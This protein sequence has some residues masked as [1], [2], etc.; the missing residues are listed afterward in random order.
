MSSRPRADQY[1]GL[2]RLTE[3]KEN[4]FLREA[5]MHP[6][7]LNRVQG[8]DRAFQFAFEGAAVVHMVSEIGNSEIV[9]V[10]EFKPDTA[11]LREPGSRHLQPDFVYSFLRHQYGTAVRRDTELSTAFF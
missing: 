3:I 1:A 4:R 7:L 10:E 9:F 5:Q 6:R 11:G 2:G 8:F